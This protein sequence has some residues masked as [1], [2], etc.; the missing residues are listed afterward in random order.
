VPCLRRAHL[1]ALLLGRRGHSLVVGHRLQPLA[2]VDGDEGILEIEQVLAGGRLLRGP[3]PMELARAPAHPGAPLGVRRRSQREDHHRADRQGRDDEVPPAL[4][5]E[6]TVGAFEHAGNG[7]S[8]LTGFHPAAIIAKRGTA[9]L[10]ERKQVVAGP[11]LASPASG[12]LRS[13]AAQRATAS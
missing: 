7:G 5:R 9:W 11:G 6:G 12:G 2:A 3:L 13:A 1:I 10:T 4:A 8:E